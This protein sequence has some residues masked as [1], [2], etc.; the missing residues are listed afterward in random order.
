ML[1]LIMLACFLLQLQLLMSLSCVHA[2]NRCSLC[3]VPDMSCRDVARNWQHVLHLQTTH[4]HA[5]DVCHRVYASGI[6]LQLQQRRHDS[7]LCVPLNHRHAVCCR[8]QVSGS[9]LQLQQQQQPASALAQPF[10]DTG[11]LSAAGRRLQTAVCICSSG[12]SWHMALT[13]TRRLSSLCGSCRCAWGASLQGRMM[14]WQMKLVRR[15]QRL[16]PTVCGW[17]WRTPALC[18]HRRQVSMT[19]RVGVRASAW[20]KQPAK[21]MS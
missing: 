3:W 7:T 19:P 15:L 5:L 6:S 13:P 18:C 8:E 2:H 20:A 10:D 17:G 11:T 21:G 16:P 4:W 9:G 1:L 14:Q 12:A